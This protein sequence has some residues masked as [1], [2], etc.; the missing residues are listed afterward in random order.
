MESN[1][2]YVMFYAMFTSDRKR[3]VKSNGTFFGSCSTDVLELKTIGKEI[4]KENPSLIV[5]PKIFKLN[6]YLDSISIDA[7]E[8]FENFG[9]KLQDTNVK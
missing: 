5:I 2:Q 9:E 1:Q 4:A 6:D 7:E 3:N 8:Y